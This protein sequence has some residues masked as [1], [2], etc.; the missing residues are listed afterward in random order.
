MDTQRHASLAQHELL[1]QCHSE[2]VTE[3]VVTQSRLWIKQ[4]KLFL[5]L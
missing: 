1:S 2:L 3:E 4:N 5:L